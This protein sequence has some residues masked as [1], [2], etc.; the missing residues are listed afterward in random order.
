MLNY[1]MLVMCPF[2][3]GKRKQPYHLKEEKMYG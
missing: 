2:G 3:S 1:Y